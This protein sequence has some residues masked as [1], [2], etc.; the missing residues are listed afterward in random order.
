MRKVQSHDSL[1][2][3]KLNAIDGYRISIDEM[4]ITAGMRGAPGFVMPSQKD[5]FLKFVQSAKY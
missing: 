4:G 2:S 1:N 3:P 5:A